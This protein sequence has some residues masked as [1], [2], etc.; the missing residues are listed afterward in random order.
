MERTKW[1][2]R[3]FGLGNSPGLLPNI[4]ER[5][6]GTPVRLR[7]ICKAL[8]DR[9]LEF[10]HAEAWSIKEH[11]GHLSDLED[12][13]EG[14]IDDFKAKKETLRAADMTNAATYK[15]NHNSQDIEHLIKV[16]ETKRQTF[17]DRLSQLDDAT[18]NFASLHPRLK[19]MM[20]PVDLAFFTAE[21]DD[22]HLAIIRE[23]LMKL[24]K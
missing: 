7:H 20:R 4:L 2:E 13:H 22:Q 5:L 23:V 18:Q 19:Q 24:G 6:R 9:D 12:L 17:I 11:I 15:A 16:F 10:K 8:K 21:H 1:M 3:Q 14:R